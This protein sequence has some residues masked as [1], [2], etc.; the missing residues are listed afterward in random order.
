MKKISIKTVKES[1]FCSK[2]TAPKT[3]KLRY[4]L[5]SGKMLTGRTALLTFALPTTYPMHST[6]H[7]QSSAF[8]RMPN[9]VQVGGFTIVIPEPF[10]LTTPNQ[11]WTDNN[12]LLTSP[13]I[14][15]KKMA[16]TH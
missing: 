13:Q 9:T 16:M 5:H 4:E 1:S 11:I 10:T 7:P 6:L 3:E 14:I 15:Q 12:Y 2:F 8:S